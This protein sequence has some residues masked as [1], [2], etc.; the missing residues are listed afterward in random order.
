M[1]KHR[2]KYLDVRYYPLQHSTAFKA[3]ECD[4]GTGAQGH[5]RLST[6]DAPRL[7][8]AARRSASA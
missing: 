6:S 3:V 5:K 2:A 1:C 7:F 8:D 4:E